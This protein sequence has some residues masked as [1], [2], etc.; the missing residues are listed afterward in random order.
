MLLATTHKALPHS[1]VPTTEVFLDQ[2][3][4]SPKIAHKK[5]SISK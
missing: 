4:R 2:Q 1:Q 3:D 5:I